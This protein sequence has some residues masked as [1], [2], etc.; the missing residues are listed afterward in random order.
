MSKTRI[1]QIGGMLF[2]IAMIAAIVAYN[3]YMKAHTYT[4]TESVQIQP[5]TGT[6]KVTSPYDTSVI[7]V[8]VKTDANY[9]IP[10][11]TSHGSESIQLEK[12]KWYRV[13]AGEGLIMSPVNVRVE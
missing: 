1:A 3:G 8:D 2:L 12:G 10:Y 9:A 6:V 13:E 7:F 5:I 11:I 4:L